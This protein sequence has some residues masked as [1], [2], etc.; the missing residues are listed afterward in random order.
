MIDGVKRFYRLRFRFGAAHYCLLKRMRSRIG[1]VLC[2]LGLL[3]IIG[4]HW[5]VLQ[6]TAWIGMVIQYSQQAGIAA[7]LTQTFDGAH[8]CSMCRA[9][10]AASKQEEKKAPLVQT[11]LK[12]D[13][14]ADESRFQVEQTWVELN[15]PGY[16][17][18][19]QSVVFRPDVPPP[20]I[21]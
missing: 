16:D 21:V 7:G 13:F 5:A 2:T 11:A 10:K 6:T 8:A 1:V 18:Q 9:I 15:Y 14:L 17:E 19:M 4:G 20:R 12:K 3:Q